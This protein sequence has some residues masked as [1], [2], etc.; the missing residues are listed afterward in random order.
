MN[1]PCL[2]THALVLDFEGCRFVAIVFYSF[3]SIHALVLDFKGCRFVA[4]VLIFFF[5]F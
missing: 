1:K 4:V 3:L 5:I 2:S